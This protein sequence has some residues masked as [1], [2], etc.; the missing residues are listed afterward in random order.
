[1]A[2]ATQD[3]LFLS[4][5]FVNDMNFPKDFSYLEGPWTPSLGFLFLFP[6]SDNTHEGNCFIDLTISFMSLAERQEYKAVFLKKECMLI[7]IRH[8][9]MFQASTLGMNI[10]QEY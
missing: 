8:D 9:K 6:L 10:K 2:Y 5:N 1:M 7:V 4:T 3:S